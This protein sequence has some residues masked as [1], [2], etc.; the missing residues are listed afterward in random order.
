[1][2]EFFETLVVH[3]PE[4]V[5]FDLFVYRRII[6]LELDSEKR[7]KISICINENRVFRLHLFCH[8]TVSDSKNSVTKI[9]C[10]D[11]I[12]VYTAV[13]ESKMCLQRLGFQTLFL[14]S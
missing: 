11:D 7:K 3:F 5:P 2:M 13:T 4:K 9:K 8:A 14:C 10:S 6:I 12:F 1:M